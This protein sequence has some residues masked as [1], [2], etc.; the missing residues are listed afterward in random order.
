MKSLNVNVTVRDENLTPGTIKWLKRQIENGEFKFGS[1]R[2]AR[3][4]VIWDFFRAEKDGTRHFVKSEIVCIL[5][6]NLYPHVEGCREYKNTF[7]SK[8]VASDE[9]YE[10]G[11]FNYLTPASERLCSAFFEELA[12]KLIEKCEND[13]DVLNI[14]VSVN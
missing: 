9:R 12:D 6:N 2:S 5:S 14:S 11:I 1:T 4:C 8:A 10:S 13:N 3:P 7:I